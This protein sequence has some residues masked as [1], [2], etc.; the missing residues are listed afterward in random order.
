MME[1][2]LVLTSMA[3]VPFKYK[4]LNEDLESLNQFIKHVNNIIIITITKSYLSFALMHPAVLE[5]GALDVALEVLEALEFLLSLSTAT[6]LS[7]HLSTLIE[8]NNNPFNQLRS[9]SS[10][11]NSW[12]TLWSKQTKTEQR[13]ILIIVI[14]SITITFLL[15]SSPPNLNHTYHSTGSLVAP[16]S[17]PVQSTL[18][19]LPTRLQTGRSLLSAGQVEC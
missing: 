15:S 14:I 9:F 11:T 1:L 8:T 7:N 18:Q 17:A 2:E 16:V 10:I 13:Q 6:L 12:N 5:V 4:S 19:R 3:L